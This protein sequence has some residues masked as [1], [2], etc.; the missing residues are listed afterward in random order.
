MKV[1]LLGTAGGPMPSPGRGAPSVAVTHGGR[2]FVVDAGNGVTHRLI[3]AG[4]DLD[5][6]S[7]V[8]LTHHHLD[9]SADLGTLVALIWATLP[10]GNVLVAGPPPLR[11]VM[12][13]FLSMHAADIRERES[14]GRVA[15]REVLEVR[16]IEGGT[17]HA[18][19][20][21][22]ITAAEVAHT[23]GLSSLAYR[24][25]GGGRSVVVSG[26]TAPCDAVVKLARDA[27]VLIHE[28]YYP[29]AL[30]EVVARG[31]ADPQ[32]VIDAFADIHTTA[33]QAGEVA[34]RARVK[35]LVLT[36][37]IPTHGIDDEEWIAH[38]RR[39]FQGE[40]VVG[41]DFQVL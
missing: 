23:P 39:Q 12:E 10:M 28:A 40:I 19:D 8:L 34:C 33:E 27:D 18:A 36:H 22:V 13:H 32:A 6:V 14:Y 35:T 25:D 24:F 37:L 1:H 16:E 3:E 30:R 15:L 31:G 20:D 7:G 17:V 2:T 41:R 38:A 5:T 26:D 29:E 21:L 11:E 9:H 4:I